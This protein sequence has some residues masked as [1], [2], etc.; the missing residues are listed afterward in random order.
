VYDKT[1]PGMIDG[2]ITRNS[3]SRAGSDSNC[4]RSASGG[5]IVASKVSAG[6]VQNLHR[7]SELKVERR[8]VVTHGSLAV[9]VVGLS[10]I[11]PSRGGHPIHYQGWECV[12]CGINIL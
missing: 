9:E 5:R 8:I 7:W 11:S 2:L 10:H 12:W 6:N 3:E 1:N 4:A